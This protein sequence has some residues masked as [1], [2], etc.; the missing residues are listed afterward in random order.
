MSPG[1]GWIHCSTAKPMSGRYKLKEVDF[2]IAVVEGI[3]SSILGEKH[4]I[5]YD[6]IFKKTM[7]GN[8]IYL[9]VLL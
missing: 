2:V 1:N 5:Y 8:A 6:P 9:Y 4:N 3:P 7:I